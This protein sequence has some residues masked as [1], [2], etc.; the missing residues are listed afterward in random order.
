MIKKFSILALSV[1][2]IALAGCS[3][4]VKSSSNNDAKPKTEK[5]TKSN[6]TKA[7]KKDTTTTPKNTNTKTTAKPTTTTNSK[8]TNNKT[9]QPVTNNNETKNVTGTTSNS[10]IVK[11]TTPTKPTPKT[12]NDTTK[13]DNSTKAKVTDGK[14]AVL[15]LFSKL[16][17]ID[18]TKV[19]GVFNG[20]IYDMNGKSTY[21]VNLYKKGESTPY[22]A[23]NVYADGTYTQVW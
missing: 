20:N 16:T 8:A 2:G 3:A 9:T 18:K 4:Q 6:Q 7:T 12:D 17:N 5:T 10:K 15:Y 11:P 22:T 1:A 21:R 23:Y 14:Q 13:K 19:S